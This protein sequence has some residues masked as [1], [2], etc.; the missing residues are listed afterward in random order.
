MKKYFG[1]IIYALLSLVVYSG[2]AK[3]P[4]LDKMLS[5]RIN[6][7]KELN[8]YEIV[9]EYDKYYESIP[10]E[11]RAG[12]KQY[13]RWKYF[14]ERRINPDGT[15]PKVG[16]VQNEAKKVEKLFKTERFLSN[17]WEL[18]GPTDSPDP[19]YVSTGVGRVNCIRF[20]PNNPNELWIG[21]AAGGVWRSTNSGNNWSKVS[22]NNQ[23]LTLG[24]TDIAI[25][26]S[27]PNVIYVATGDAF[28]A[29]STGYDTY[30]IGIVKSTDG[31][32]S[33][34]QTNLEFELQTV[35]LVGRVLVH[36]ENENI[37]I[38]AT[39]NGIFKTIDGGNSWELKNSSYYF[40]DMEFKEDDPN[41]IIASTF[42][43]G[44]G[45]GFIVRSTDNG[46]T[47]NN[48]ATVQG[49]KRIA[50]ATTPAAPDY[51]YALSGYVSDDNYNSFEF[52]SDAGATWIRTSDRSNSV[53]VLGR[54]ASYEDDG[55]AWYDLALAVSP[56]DPN[57]LY[58]GGID[59][60]RSNSIG[61][62]YSVV[63][64]NRARNGLPFVH[65]DIHDLQY[66]PD[67]SKIYAGTDGG[68]TLSTNNG[69]TW[70]E[71]NTDLAITQY[72]KLALSQKDPNFIMGGT[73]DNGTSRL[74]EGEWQIVNEGDGMDCYISPIDDRNVIS[75]V[76]YGVFY[77]SSN[78]GNDFSITITS[79]SKNETATW[80]AP[81]AYSESSPNTV[82]VG[83]TNVWKSTSSGG[84]PWIKISTFGDNTN[85]PLR[86]L[87]VAPSNV[88]YMYA[89]TGNTIRRT[90]DGGSSP[91]T[92]TN[93]PGGFGALITGIAV[94]PN[95]PERFW[96]SIGQFNAANKIWE[97][98]GTNWHNRSGNLPNIPIN[99]ITYQN[100]SPDRLY[101]GTDIGVWYS[102]YNSGYWEP[103]GDGIPGTIVSDIE[104]HYDTKKIFAAT[105]G[106]GIWKTDLIDCNLPQP[107]IEAIGNTVVCP[108]ETVSLRYLGDSP[109]FKWSNGETT[110]EINVTE[111]ATYVVVIED[112]TGCTAKSNPITVEFIEFNPVV[113]SVNGYSGFC[114][115]VNDEVEIS[116]SAGF[117]TYLWSNGETERTIKVSKAGQYS[118]IATTRDGCTSQSEVLDVQTVPLPEKPVINQFGRN[119]GVEDNYSSYQWFRDG[120]IIFNQNRPLLENISEDF[121]GSEFTVRVTNESGCPNTS[122]PYSFTTSVEKTDI[123]ESITVSPNPSNGVFDLKINIQNSKPID[124]IITNLAGEEIYSKRNIILNG[125]L[126]HNIN[127]TNQATGVYMLNINGSGFTWNTK[128]IK[129]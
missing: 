99:T 41:I 109:N 102:D 90:T 117:E 101:I 7:G 85:N 69:Q 57:S 121:L 30:S 18:V 76:Y 91:W 74:R 119:L 27:A 65:A 71:L 32:Q 61:T 50:L 95:N 84:A 51:M 54:D 21:A 13:E 127:I 2:F 12:W 3:T 36:P 8:F 108:G 92:L 72:Y 82:I 56:I 19:R 86:V 66:S 29:R 67:G 73:Q 68:V 43:F 24:V 96:V 77:R 111:S 93:P 35:S 88:N 28:G 45:R 62:T 33:W 59:I 70:V 87:A 1:I 58:T 17:E 53:N 20:H 23:F 75:S 128:L 113:L 52:S 80:V 89:A 15:F 107:Q 115:G 112:G 31:G 81:L 97:F 100:N 46:E 103:F 22:P 94:D 125:Q 48:V 129:K 49:A 4:A 79:N 6:D 98:D 16:I 60:W 11:N 63:T 38:A 44:T 47:W 55:Q 10:M 110:K 64:N 116:A 42:T 9:K 114:E 124:I 118:V 37:A 34:F 14:Y 123:H 78:Y 105:H 106:R 126:E 104:I 83:F 122:D 25:A 40:I 39:S 26:P 5:E 120:S